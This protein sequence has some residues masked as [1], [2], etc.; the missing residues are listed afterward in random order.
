MQPNGSKKSSGLL[1]P[2]FPSHLPYLLTF[3]S[4]VNLPEN[5]GK[6]VFLSFKKILFYNKFSVK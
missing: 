1:H 5:H 3:Q 2:H 4:I 6:K